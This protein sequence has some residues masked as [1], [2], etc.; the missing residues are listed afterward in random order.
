MAGLLGLAL[1][2]ASAAWG[3]D[4]AGRWL[5]RTELAICA[6]PQLRRLEE[7]IA[8]RIKG[9]AQRLTFGQYLGLR[10]W[11][12]LRANE[13]NTCVTNRECI[14]ASLQAERRLLNRLQ[15][16]VTSNLT[17]RACL[18]NLLANERHSVRR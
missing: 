5:S 2:G 15:R 7:Q 14:A 8:R 18:R 16:C 6:D 1:F 12:A 13:R 4:C 11:H 10:H 9:N 17:R 3:S